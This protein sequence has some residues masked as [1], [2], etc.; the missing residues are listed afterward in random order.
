MKEGIFHQ[1]SE[2]SK[3]LIGV[4]YDF[5]E[6]APM[7]QVVGDAQTQGWE[8]EKKHVISIMMITKAQGEKFIIQ[9]LNGNP[10][11]KYLIPVDYKGIEILSR[12]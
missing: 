4:C 3:L 9:Y 10:Q 12:A 8:T 5:M 1:E 7:L 11:L 6:E 2:G